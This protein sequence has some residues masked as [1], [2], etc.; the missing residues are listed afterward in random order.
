MA[1]QGEEALE[2]VS[3]QSPESCVGMGRGGGRGAVYLVMEEQVSKFTCLGLSPSAWESTQS[4]GAGREVLQGLLP[5]ASSRVPG[6]GGLG[7][8]V[9]ESFVFLGSQFSVYSPLSTLQP[10]PYLDGH[11][12]P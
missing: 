4:L 2:N 7:P 8:L 10:P 1:L 6:C 5:P 3:T 12:V 11:P 9:V